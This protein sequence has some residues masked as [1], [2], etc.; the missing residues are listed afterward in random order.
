VDSRNITQTVVDI[1][2]FFTDE[3]CEVGGKFFNTESELGREEKFE[4]LR[5]WRTSDIDMN[6]YKLSDIFEY[7]TLASHVNI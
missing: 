2:K 7:V 5:N 3:Y 1:C 4:K 6:N